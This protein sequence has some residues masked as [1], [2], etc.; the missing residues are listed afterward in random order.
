MADA[1][2]SRC[3]QQKENA[4]W[5]QLHSSVVG[6]PWHTTFQPAAITTALHGGGF[7]PKPN[8]SVKLDRRDDGF[9]SLPI[10]STF[11]N[12]QIK[13]VSP[14]ESWEAPEQISPLALTSQVC[15]EAATNESP[16]VPKR[17]YR[18]THCVLL[19]T[20]LRVPL[21]PRSS[22]GQLEWKECVIGQ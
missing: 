9:L 7:S 4:Q 6:S 21:H 1:L 18:A 5:S 20:S 2:D 8:P 15:F 17:H 3:C 13:A 19:P 11:G 10:A 12:K 22:W 14:N 16:A